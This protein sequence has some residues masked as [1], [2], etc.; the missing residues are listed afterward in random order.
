MNYKVLLHLN[1]SVPL[2]YEICIVSNDLCKNK[3]FKI[4]YW[5]FVFLFLFLFKYCTFNFTR[6]SKFVSGSCLSLLYSFETASNIMCW[7]VAVYYIF[8]FSV[9]KDYSQERDKEK[10]EEHND[11]LPDVTSF[12]PQGIYVNDRYSTEQWIKDLNIK[13]KIRQEIYLKS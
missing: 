7:N 12:P 4:C 8:W 11:L 13:N 5:I 10:M 3:A 2:W 6:F 1:H 9:Q